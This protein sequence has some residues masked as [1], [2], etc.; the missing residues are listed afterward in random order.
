MIAATLSPA[1]PST[2]SPGFVRAQRR[3]SHHEVAV[4]PR[5]AAPA[6]PRCWRLSDV[7]HSTRRAHCTKTRPVRAPGAAWPRAVPVDTPRHVVGG[8][9]RSRLAAAA[10]GIRPGDGR[11]RVS[12]FFVSPRL[13]AQMPVIVAAIGCE[14]L[15]TCQPQIGPHIVS[16]NYAKLNPARLQQSTIWSLRQKVESPGLSKRR[17]CAFDWPT[18]RFA[19]LGRSSFWRND[20]NIAMM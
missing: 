14:P 16:S 12:R 7:R 2:E 9:E 11:K 6:R 18:R 1:S 10:G 20:H 17:F 15:G 5:G 13:S 8:S 4:R 3:R 19:S